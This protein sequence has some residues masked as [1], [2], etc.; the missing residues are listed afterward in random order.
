MKIIVKKLWG[1]NAA[2][3]YKSSLNIISDHKEGKK[4]VIVVSAIRASDFNTTD[5]LISLWEELWKEDIN[6]VK[7]SKILEWLSK[8]HKQ[9]CEEKL[10][11]TDIDMSEF[12]EDSFIGLHKKIDSYILQRKEKII[13]CSDNDYSIQD[14]DWE[15]CS[16][17][18][19]GEILSAGILSRVIIGISENN[20]Q[21]QRVD[22][23][24]IIEGNKT[25]GKN[26]RE[27]FK[28]LEDKIYEQAQKVLDQGSIPVIGG[29]MW[30]FNEGIENTIGRW[31]TDATAAICI[32]W[33]SH[34]GYE[35]I[36]EIQ[37]SVRWVLSADP[38]VLHNPD[39]ARLITQLDYVTARE[40]TGDSWA[41]AKLLH[42]QAIREEVQEAGVKI[43][44]FDPFCTLRRSGTWVVPSIEIP[45]DDQLSRLFIGGRSNIVF[46]SISSWKMFQAGLLA[47]IFTIVKDYFSVDII[48]AS[49]TE[50]SFTIDAAKDIKEKLDKMEQ[51]LRMTCNIHE[52]TNMEF[53]E[54]ATDM[55]LVFCVW[56]HMRDKIGLL[57]RAS[58]TLSKNDINIE[59]VSQGRLQRAMV[60]GIKWK[61]L[62]K[63]INALH[64]EFIE[65][66][67]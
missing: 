37:K 13:P 2:E 52:N 4:Q 57:A 64:E 11:H 7:V 27:I 65:N 59:I 30:V 63:A 45:Q 44:L 40:I 38:R 41:N 43:H 8:F 3:L 34:H 5:M 55:A 46:F 66:I 18:G 9:I 25:K 39:S 49:E 35:W 23:S 54:Y 6:R 61:D 29:Y 56:Q 51:E 17:V 62:K 19:F 14:Q 32:V 60:F 33:F 16:I 47:K 28:L 15:I 50:V 48:S 53:V 24:H 10:S 12:I 1:E 21:A 20:V 58:N 26:E 42:S 31:Y 22:L 67:S 36:L